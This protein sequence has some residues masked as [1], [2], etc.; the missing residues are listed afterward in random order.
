MPDPLKLSIGAWPQ[1]QNPQIDLHRAAPAPH[2][3][4]P[5]GNQP[6]AR[7]RPSD[8]SESLAG[9]YEILKRDEETLRDLIVE[10]RLLYHNLPEKDRKRLEAQRAQTTREVADLFSV[11][12]RLLDET[13]ARLRG[14][15]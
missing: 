9:I 15:R 11:R 14:A 4:V 1:D 5:A 12:I 10:V 13:I 7:E 3:T 2:S 6:A 8:S